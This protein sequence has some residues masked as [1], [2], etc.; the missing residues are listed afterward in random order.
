MAR[1]ATARG[2]RAS[3]VGDQ[4]AVLSA[5]CAAT[6]TLRYRDARTAFDREYFAALLEE[7][8]YNVHA[9]AKASGLNRTHIYKRLA[10]L[11]LMHLLANRPTNY[12]RKGKWERV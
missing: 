7:C 11:D 1:E 3:D 9:A 5:P 2:D 4:L 8:G 6:P 12:G 10:L